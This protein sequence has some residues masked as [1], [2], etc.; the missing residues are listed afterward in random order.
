MSI[1]HADKLII[2]PDISEIRD[3]IKA[4]IRVLEGERDIQPGKN[5]WVAW[6]ESDD[7]IELGILERLMI[8]LN[9]EI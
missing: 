4:R 2:P 8:I 1:T 5:A 9:E 6:Q 3:Y 7:G